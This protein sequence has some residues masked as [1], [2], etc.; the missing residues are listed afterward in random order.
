[1]WHVLI[2][3]DIQPTTDTFRTDVYYARGAIFDVRWSQSDKAIALA[4]AR[5]EALVIDAEY[6]STTATMYGHAR[7][8]KVVR[9]NPYN[10]NMLSTGSRDG[11]IC[12]WDLRAQ[13]RGRIRPV[14]RILN[15]H[16]THRRIGT[17]TDIAYGDE[18]V[19]YSSSNCDA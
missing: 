17:V 13:T 12:I 11:S 15:P 5:S 16:S 2:D 19:L 18:N 8:Q 1:M 14:I 4:T 10:E 7:S 9:W 3:L 6:G